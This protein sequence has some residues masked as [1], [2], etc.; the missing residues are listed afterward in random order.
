M[1]GSY[2]NAIRH[3]VSVK[4]SLLENI[5]GNLLPTMSITAQAQL[6]QLNAIADN[7]KIN[8]DAALE[9]QKSAIAIQTS[10]LSVITQGKSGKAIRIQ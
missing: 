2:L 10:L 9:I 4:R 6:Q 1:L 3:D 8:A 5:A 7:T